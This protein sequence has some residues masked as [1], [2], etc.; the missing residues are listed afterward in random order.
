M[1]IAETGDI[2]E[3]HKSLYLSMAVIYDTAYMLSGDEMY[4]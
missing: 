3:G 2:P 1:E 4:K